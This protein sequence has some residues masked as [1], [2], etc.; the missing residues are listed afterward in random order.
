LLAGGYGTGLYFMTY[1]AYDP[2]SQTIL[3]GLSH[4]APGALTQWPAGTG[5]CDDAAHILG[6]SP[7]LYGVSD[8]VLSN[9]GC[10]IH[11]TFAIDQ[12]HVPTGFSVVAIDTNQPGT[13]AWPDAPT[14]LGQPFILERG[15]TL[16]PHSTTPVSFSI[17]SSAYGSTY[18]SM[19]PGY[20]LDI[21][22]VNAAG[23]P[24]SF[25]GTVIFSTSDHGSTCAN[26]W[27][28]SA[29]VHRRNYEVGT[30]RP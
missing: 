10:S 12:N 26:Q 14:S 1:C 23:D 11:S 7:S 9:I 5:S 28:N 19:A 20:R 29:V 13:V 16:T 30:L 22:A 8:G 27:R 17:K 4:T 18:A 6:E 15:V 25:T 2:D 3:N 21:G 24:V